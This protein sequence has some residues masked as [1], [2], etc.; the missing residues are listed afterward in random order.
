MSRPTMDDVARRAGVSRALVSLVM[1]NSSKVSESRRRAV[2]RAADDLG[3][4]PNLHARNLAQQRSETFGVVINDIHNPFFAEV[5]LGIETV[6]DDHGF[7]VLVLNGGRDVERERRAVETHLQFQV[8]ALILVGPSLTAEDLRAAACVAP[9]VV[10]AS[11]STHCDVDTISTDDLTGAALAVEHLRNLGH[12]RIVHLD[13]ADNIS[14]APRARG[15]T[16]AMQAAGLDPW[17]KRAGDDEGAAA[18]PVGELLHS[19]TPPTAI[20]AFN[21]LVAAGTLDALHTRGI[22]VP[23]DMSVVGYDNTFIAGLNHLSITTID[24]PRRTMGE[25]AAAA[26]IERLDAGRS[27]PTHIELT[28]TIEIRNS[29][30]PT[31][32]V[33]QKRKTV[34]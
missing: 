10:V 11:G 15:Y 16:H 22:K 28:P 21:D 9:T 17:V 31:P 7:T 27:E 1:N 2:L 25:L 13:G 5:L 23:D 34:P 32:G 6:A 3:Y 18:A 19:P 20:F 33:G 14:A 26:V 12:T 29:T 8:E 4:R 24:Q 30:G